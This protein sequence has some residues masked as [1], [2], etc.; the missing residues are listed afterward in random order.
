MTKQTRTKEK[1]RTLQTVEA[2]LQEV[3]GRVAELRGELQVASEVPEVSWDGVTP[4][5]LEELA[6]SEKK[7]LILPH[8]I[9]AGE[10]R[11]R[12]LMAEIAEL[13]MP[14]ADAAIEEH[15]Q[16]VQATEE[17]K[18]KAQEEYDAASLAWSEAVKH[19]H[20]LVAEKRQAE[21]ELAELRS[22]ASRERE[23]LSAPLVR[24]TWQARSRA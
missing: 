17:A 14:A 15:Y 11:E 22:T 18:R 20:G 12:E 7:R 23:N 21:R 16:K 5:S 3:R 9:R 2:E 1:P 19:R 6:E 13:R 24:S 4:E 8:H 10:I